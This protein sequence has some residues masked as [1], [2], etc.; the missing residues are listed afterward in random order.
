MCYAAADRRPVDM[1]VK[2]DIVRAVEK[3]R[4]NLDELR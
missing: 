4:D 1:D 2:L 3:I